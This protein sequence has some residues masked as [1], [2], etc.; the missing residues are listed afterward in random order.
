MDRS[1][2]IRRVFLR[3]YLPGHGPVFML[4][5]HDENIRRNGRDRL[6]YRLV[7]IEGGHGSVPRTRTVLFTGT[8]YG[9]SPLHSIDGDGSIAG[10]LGFLTLRPGDTDAE[11]FEAY[12]PE[13][14]AYCDEHAETL[15]A[16]SVARFG[17]S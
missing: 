1:T 12:T 15:A 5:V 10:L 9:C 8:D 11:Y 17:E 16:E 13:Q 3:P 6:S 4:D 14:L 2:R 7:M